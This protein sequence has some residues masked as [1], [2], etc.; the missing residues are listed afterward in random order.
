MDDLQHLRQTLDYYKEKKAKRTAEFRAE[1]SALD[2]QIRQLEQELGEEP[3][4]GD[5]DVT[6]T[7]P[8][9]PSMRGGTSNP[10]IRPDEFFGMSQSEASK[11][12][13]R[14]VAR[15]IPFDQLVDALKRGGAELGGANPKRTLYVSLARNP[16][17]E[18]VYPS[19][20]FIGLREFYP[21]LSKGA[22]G[23]KKS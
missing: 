17:K 22:K 19:D 5:V 9:L 21:N 10:S 3:S 14:K 6:L 8:D 4:T 12:Y 7:L 11:A 15:A 1:V 13:L 20:G 16:M 18:F 23:K 2:I